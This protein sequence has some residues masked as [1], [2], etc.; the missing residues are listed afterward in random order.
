MRAPLGHLLFLAAGIL[1][2]LLSSGCTDPWRTVQYLEGLRVLAVRAEPPDL[3]P[4]Q[5]TLL[6]A[7][8]V[9]PRAPARSNTVLW[10]ACHPDPASL[11]QPKCAEYDTLE[12]L[13]GEEGSADPASL[14]E[15]LVPLGITAPAGVTPLP[16]RYA[17]P[18]DVFAG[19]AADD[20]RRVRGVLAMVLVLAIAEEP[21]PHWPPT[22]EDLSALMD[23]VRSKQVDSVLAIK[24]LR[25]SE[26]ATP[27]HNPVLS[28]VRLGDEEWGPGPQPAKIHP[29][30]W[31]KVLALPAPE[32]SET[33]QDLDADGNLVTKQEHLSAS[34]FTTLGD[35]D[36][37]RTLA[38]EIED[39]EALYAPFV[40][41]NVP[42]S[43][44]GVLYAVL[45]D[46]RGGVDQLVRD[47]FLCDPNRAAPTLTSVE[48]ASG[49]A[50]TLV[51]LRGERLDDLLDARAGTGWLSA[52]A[53]DEVEKAYVGT[54][55][56]DAPLGELAIVPRGKG[57][58]T[59]PRGT[60]SV[61]ASP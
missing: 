44:Q 45:R 57:C 13:T 14:P 41:Q 53:W 32:T 42:E 22:Q 29:G 5:A 17:A 10:L 35:L 12:A 52:A 28:K 56:T 50:G 37:A 49:P 51:R 19:L 48:P 21:S 11:D 4:G 38:G 3:A 59:D 23:R 43:R 54:L 24:R 36:K 60:F 8:V 25:I 18:A 33:Y 34:W 46:G 40:L 15:G 30:T 1:A 6:D 61:T 55:P 16:I 27:N 31:T 9:D 39:P 26:T 58:G 7:L 20:P 47:F 2:P